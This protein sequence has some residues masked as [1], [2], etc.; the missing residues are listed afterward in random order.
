MVG[1][2]SPL[3]AGDPRSHWD[4]AYSAD[5]AHVAYVDEGSLVVAA[6]D[7]SHAATLISERDGLGRVTFRS[8]A[9]SPTGDRI[10]F[11]ARARSDRRL[12]HR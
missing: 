6:G 2:N 8:L 10:A 11:A 12:R 7:G 4:A 3:P 9:W 1:R 5:G